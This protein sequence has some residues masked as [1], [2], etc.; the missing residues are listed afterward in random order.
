MMEK[1]ICIVKLVGNLVVSNLCS[2]NFLDYVDTECSSKL[3]I[4]LCS[5]WVN[6]V[7][8]RLLHLSNQEN[9]NMFWGSCLLTEVFKLNLYLLVEYESLIEA[10]RYFEQF[11]IISIS[12]KQSQAL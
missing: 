12:M 9:N 5:S 7:W 4:V 1:M 3:Y 10:S 8:D 2:I 11:H 6:P